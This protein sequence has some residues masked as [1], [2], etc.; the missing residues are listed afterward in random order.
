MA[1]PVP[2]SLTFR[3]R[4]TGKFH[5]RARGLRDRAVVYLLL[6]T[7]LR[8]EE[9]VHLDLDQVT[10]PK[11]TGLRAAKK[12]KINGV[13][14]KGLTTQHCS[15][16]PSRSAPTDP[17]GGFPLGRS[18]RSA[19]RLVAGTMLSTPTSPTTSPRS[20]R[21]TCYTALPTGSRP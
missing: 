17:T 7:G 14:G 6:A 2:K 12:T 19:S 21:M 16:P 18:T 8:R 5:T 11:P 15:C 20:A 13:R 9:L 3:Q 1:T 10:P 4:G